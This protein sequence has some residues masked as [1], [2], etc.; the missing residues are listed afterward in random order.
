MLLLYDALHLE[1]EV[2][3]CILIILGFKWNFC[4][5]SEFWHIHSLKCILLGEYWLQPLCWMHGG[6][7]RWIN[8]QINYKVLSVK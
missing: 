4:E 5:V 6:M 2:K 8:E 3:V 7:E 1:I